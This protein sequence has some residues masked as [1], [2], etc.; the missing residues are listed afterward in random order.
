[1]KVGII[2]IKLLQDKEEGG[3][4]MKEEE[5]FLEQDQDPGRGEVEFMRIGEEGETS[6]HLIKDK[7]APYLRSY[8]QN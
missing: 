2:Q 7:F 1:M 4:E 8:S 3:E 6:L 5:D